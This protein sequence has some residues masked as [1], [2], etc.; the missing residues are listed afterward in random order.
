MPSY[1]IVCPDANFVVNGLRQAG[2]YETEIAA[3]WVALARD[4]TRLLAPSLLF[5]EVTNVFYQLERNGK[6]S[7]DEA[8]RLLDAAARIPFEFVEY[9]AIHQE[10]LEIARDF[11]QK[12]TYDAHY[13]AVAR[14]EQ[15][16]LVTS[17]RRMINIIED[18][19]IDAIYIPFVDVYE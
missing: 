7:S 16:P 3:K 8:T 15:I 1:S 14:R 12:A 6:I 19:Y 18:G 13:V 17:D 5:Y 4:R 10:A 11:G 9:P 2:Q